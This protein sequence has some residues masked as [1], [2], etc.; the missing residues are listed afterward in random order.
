LQFLA[1]QVVERERLDAMVA[2]MKEAYGVSVRGWINDAVVFWGAEAERALYETITSLASRSVLFSVSAL[3]MSKAEY[4]MFVEEKFGKMDWAALPDEMI[5]SYECGARFRKW[6]YPAPGTDEA[7]PSH[8]YN[9]AAAV[10]A[11]YIVYNFSFATGKTEYYDEA[12][13][14]WMLEGGEYMIK[15]LPLQRVLEAR[16]S[17]YTMAIEQK[18]D[19]M[20]YRACPERT[21]PHRIRLAQTL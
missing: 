21:S 5:F 11:P 20:S 3:T 17:N 14:V 4:K 9:L 13:G 8:P 7:R 2:C 16:V 12:N 10:V 19:T 1:S 15:G 6:L 18:G